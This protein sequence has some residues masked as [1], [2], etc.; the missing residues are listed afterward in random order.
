MSSIISCLTLLVILFVNCNISFAERPAWC[1]GNAA[2][3]SHRCDE[4]STTSSGTRQDT[5]PVTSQSNNDATSI[6]YD[7][8]AN[9]K[10]IDDAK[11]IWEKPSV[12]PHYNQHEYSPQ[13]SYRPD[14]TKLDRLNSEIE[15][16]EAEISRS[17]ESS[18]SPQY[19]HQDVRSACQNVAKELAT[20]ENSRQA[21]PT[22]EWGN[23]YKVIRGRDF[24]VDVQI[25]KNDCANDYEARIRVVN[26]SGRRGSV[27]YKGKFT[28]E[29]G[30][31]SNILETCEGC[32]SWCFPGA[33]S[34]TVKPYSGKEYV[35]FIGKQFDTPLYQEFPE[36]ILEIYLEVE[37]TNYESFKG[38]ESSNR[39]FSDKWRDNNSIYIPLEPASQLYMCGN[40]LRKQELKRQ[41]SQC[42]K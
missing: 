15:E 25:T 34:C 5:T 13:S 35:R 8:N 10:L 11:S 4:V 24:N 32:H 1:D 31:T 12:R 29:H 19:R 7:S 2:I 41:L 28:S 23:W 37:E 20:I 6:L 3:Y 9:N 42:I 21:A 14:T 18:S 17:E 33:E 16:L 39:D 38:T 40:L 36:K 26:F 27:V 22:L 30:N